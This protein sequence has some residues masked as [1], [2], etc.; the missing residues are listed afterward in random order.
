M[1]H[2]NLKCLICT[3]RQEK[4]YRSASGYSLILQK[5]RVTQNILDILVHNS[6]CP[7]LLVRIEHSNLTIDHMLLTVCHLECDLNSLLLTG[8][9]GT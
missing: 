8:I 3:P 6:I 1:K 5:N 2:Y 9:S 7:F 4:F